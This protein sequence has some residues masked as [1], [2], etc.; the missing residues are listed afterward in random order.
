MSTSFPFNDYFLDQL[1]DGKRLRSQ[2]YRGRFAPSPSGCLHLGN[3]RTALVS[4]LKARL[5]NGLWLLRIDDLDSPRNR[6]GAVESIQSDLRWLGLNWDG[7]SIFQSKRRGLYRLALSGL[8]REGKLYACRC[9]RRMVHNDKYLEGRN[10][11]YPGNCKGSNYH[12]SWNEG[13]LPS[14]RLNVLQKYKKDSGDIVI[15]RSDG[16]IAYHLATVVDELILGINEVV[17]GEDLKR[18]LYPQLALIEELGADSLSYIHVPIMCDRNGRKLSK[19]SSSIGL[20]PL[21]EKGIT[22]P[23]VVGMLADSLGLIPKGS[24]IS[25]KELLS[26]L[27]KNKDSI[28]KAFVSVEEF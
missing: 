16:Y 1:N 3:L 28:S 5:F 8:R 4:W 10:Y 14:I 25:A 2:G 18:A 6:L 21:K 23:Q 24:A 13:R 19:R 26:E 20:Q 17:R 7:P 11:I 12:W 27:C 9:S 15:R 22:S